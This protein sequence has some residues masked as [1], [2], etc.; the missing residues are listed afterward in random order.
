MT[1]SPFSRLP[2]DIRRMIY[3][4]RVKQTRPVVQ[5]EPDGSGKHPSG[6]I[7]LRLALASKQLF[8][9]VCKTFFEENII[10][11]DIM[12]GS[13]V[14]LPVLFD[15]GAKSAKVWP[16]EGSNVSTSMWNTDRKRT[17]TSF[18]QNSRSLSMSSRA[19][20]WYYC[21]SPL[22]VPRNGFTKVLMSLSIKHLLPSSLSNPKNFASQKT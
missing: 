22:A 19:V 5:M 7:D 15:P 4:L 18:A 6:P 8:D 11:L 21:K 9:E 1:F 17:T 14:G 10:Q 2:F 12:P 13:A 20:R 16:F 3:V